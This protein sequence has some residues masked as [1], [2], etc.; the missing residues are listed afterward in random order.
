MQIT[1]NF[2]AS[3]GHEIRRQLA[4]MFGL[5][6]DGGGGG[7]EGGGGNPPDPSQIWE[8]IKACLEAGMGGPSTPEQVHQAQNMLM[9]TLHDHGVVLDWYDYAGIP[10]PR[11]Q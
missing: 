4:E 10:D 5:H 1:L 8:L 9:W 3:T 11:K 2:D 6:L 7:G